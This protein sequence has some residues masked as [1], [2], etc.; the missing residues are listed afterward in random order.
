MTTLLAADASLMLVGCADYPWNRTTMMEAE[1]LRHDGN[2]KRFHM[3][4]INLGSVG[5]LHPPGKLFCEIG[6]DDVGVVALNFALLADRPVQT[7][8]ALRNGLG[9]FV[10]ILALLFLTVDKDVVSSDEVRAGSP[11]VRVAGNVTQED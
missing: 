11:L 4:D 1:S 3:I 10:A 9:L 7:D 6:F 8:E 2:L 5:R